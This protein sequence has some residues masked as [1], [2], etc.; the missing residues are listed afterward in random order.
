MVNKS[1][2]G[3]V[4][5]IIT[6]LFMLPLGYV[7]FFLAMAA[8]EGGGSGFWV[9]LVPLIHLLFPI[10]GVITS[11]SDKKLENKTLKSVATSLNGTLIFL[12]SLCL[13]LSILIV[14]FF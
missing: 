5:G 9:I 10:I 7:W 11:S 3:I 6:I 8:G 12:L 2:V 13:I 1:I 14:L 4:F